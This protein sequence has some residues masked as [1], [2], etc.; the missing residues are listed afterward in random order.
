MSC[1]R[2]LPTGCAGLTGTQFIKPS[3]AAG[4]LRVTCN[5]NGVAIGGPNAFTTGENGGISSAESQCGTGG[6]S[7]FDYDY[8]SIAVSG[9]SQAQAYADL[10]L[11]VDS[12]AMCQQPFTF[13]CDGSILTDYQCVNTASIKLATYA[14]STNC[15]GNQDN[16][17][18]TDTGVL[19][20]SAL[21]V[22]MLLPGD[23]GGGSEHNSQGRPARGH[24]S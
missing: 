2:T 9:Q 12:Q 19:D 4:P 14:D 10:K 24:R 1:V 17:H 18:Q 8:R 22:Q 5:A 16:V 20:S 6:H 21:P 11:L 15:D 3:G 7:G 13:K 23:I